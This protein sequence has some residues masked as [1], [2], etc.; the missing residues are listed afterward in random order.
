MTAAA[1]RP[2]LPLTVHLSGLRVVGIGAG[3]VAW[4]KYRSLLESGAALTVIAPAATDEVDAADKEGRL[5]WRR[6]AYQPGDLAGAVLAV[7]ATADPVVNE[8]VAAE[9]AATQTLCVR[10]D[11]GGTAGLVAVVHRGPLMLSVSTGGAA[12]ALARRLRA[13]LAERYGEEYG[14]LA[15]LLGELRAD[16]NVRAALEQL[17]PRLRAA[18]WRA[19]ASADSLGLLRAGRPDLAKEAALAC[20][21]SSS[22]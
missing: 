16:S 2:G 22:D 15:S 17:P 20:L 10:V 1:P 4:A 8:Q 7:A 9:A 14:Q 12:P 6:R 5:T 21:F 18:R 13:E 19:A 3:R 11:G